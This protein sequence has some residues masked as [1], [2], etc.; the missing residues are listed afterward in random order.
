MIFL[1]AIDLFEGNVIRLT[2]GDFSKKKDYRLSPLETAKSFLDAG[3]THIHI[4]DLEGAKSGKPCHLDLLEKIAS[5]GMFVQYGGGLR[6]EGNIRDALRAGAA[7]VMIGSL[8]F[9]NDDMPCHI[10]SEFG[11]TAMPA[12]DVR[13]GKVVY[14]GWLNETVMTPKEA[15]TWLREIGFSVFLVTNTDLDGMMSGADPELYRELTGGNND[16]V[17]AGGITTADDIISLRAVG[18]AGAIVG[19]SLYEGG[20]TIAEALSATSGGK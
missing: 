3:C 17:A 4:V 13:G 9:K 12:I 19:K 6:S 18:V 16:I 1:P 14:S 11:P 5:L 8:L 7:R 10:L 15:L 20:I 2:K